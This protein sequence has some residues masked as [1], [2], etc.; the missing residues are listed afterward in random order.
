MTGKE[1]KQSGDRVHADQDGSAAVVQMAG[2]DAGQVSQEKVCLQEPPSCSDEVV[3]E[4]PQPTYVPAAVA[5]G[6]MM[7]LWGILTNWIMSAAG[8]LV[9]AWAV[10]GW[11]REMH[12]S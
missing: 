6:V 7:L 8:A 2:S 9:M 10:T 3:V 4:E 1:K 12:E 5:M 11:V